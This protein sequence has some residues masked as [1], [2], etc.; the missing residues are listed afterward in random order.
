MVF[1]TWRPA[2]EAVRA[3]LGPPS[4]ELADL[5]RRLDVEF[6]RTWPAFV[7]AAAVR[8]RV[9]PLL[10]ERPV[11]PPTEAQEDYLSTL[12]HEVGV[13]VNPPRTLREA[14]GWIDFLLATRTAAVLA[15]M[16]PNRGDVVDKFRV[17]EGGERGSRHV[18]SS[19]RDDG[20]VYFR[21]AN[22]YCGWAS[23]LQMIARVGTPEAQEALAANP[24]Q[25]RYVG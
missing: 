21:G 1:H 12:S 11:Q 17:S 4:G 20:L 25:M 9:D 14:S 19:I 7:V 16:K 24:W 10:H 3:S 5:A 8:D 15:Q 23:S 22:G 2:L 13:V 6:E 18:I